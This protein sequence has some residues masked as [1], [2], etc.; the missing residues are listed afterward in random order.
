MAKAQCATCG[1]EW[2]RGTSGSHSCSIQF[3]KYIK[4]ILLYCNIHEQN[5][6]NFDME[7]AEEQDNALIQ[8][9]AQL[10]FFDNGK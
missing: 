2:E 4:N 10:E 5:F 1:Y 6:S 8:I 9:K 3:H 7:L